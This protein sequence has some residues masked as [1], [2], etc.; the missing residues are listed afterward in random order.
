MATL[1]EIRNRLKSVKSTQQLTKAM[2]MVAASKLR[3]AQERTI[4][5]RPYGNKLEELLLNLI[6]GV[7]RS[8]FPLLKER[9]EAGKLNI[10]SVGRKSE[11]FFV[12]RGYPLLKTFS[13]VFS[14]LNYSSAEN[15]TELI[16]SGYLSNKFD[17]IVLIYNKF[18]NVLSPEM[19][20][21][22][23]LPITVK[24]ASGSKWK[25]EYIYEPSV[26]ENIQAL[27]P[28]YLTLQ[29][30]RT[31]MESNAA[32]EASRMAAMDSAT[33]NA[34]ELIRSLSVSYNRARQASIT[35]E[36]IEIISG[37]NALDS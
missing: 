17:K 11:D 36:L 2:R 30:W 9:S 3:R 23:L 33:E 8:L 12:R 29:I 4:N 25:P 27:L 21:E 28:K 16:L 14:K 20:K 7:D 10:I 15:I 5:A 1:K 24:H 19:K 13:G 18:K 35:K 37:A 26:E 31:L 34:K 32:E 6:N 22:I